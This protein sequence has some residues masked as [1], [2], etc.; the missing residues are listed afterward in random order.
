[1]ASSLFAQL[2]QSLGAVRDPEG[3]ILTTPFLSTCRELVHVI[4]KFGTALALVKSDVGG[5]ID[6][7]EAAHGR[8]PT[9]YTRIFD[10]LSDEV[11]TGQPT[12]SSSDTNGLLWLK[13]ALEF[14]TVILLRLYDDRTVTL[15]TAASESYTATLYQYH[16]WYTAAAFTVALKLVPSR[17]TFFQKVGTPG[18]QLMEDMKHFTDSFTPLLQQIHQFLVDHDLDFK[19]RV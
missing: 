16:T 12:G 10:I 5:N 14:T 4:E 13:R 6:R 15:S 18:E 2:T 17:E 1:M 19:T 3:N 7:L 11:N 9:K 8:N